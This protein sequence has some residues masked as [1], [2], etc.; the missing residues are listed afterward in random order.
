MANPLSAFSVLGNHSTIQT[1]VAAA[2]NGRFPHALLLEGPR[3]SGKK[4]LARYLAAS[5]LCQGENPPCGVCNSCHKAAGDFHPD[6]VFYGLEESGARSF[7]IDQIRQLK[8][9]AYVLPNESPY[10][11]FILCGAQNM[12]VQAQNALLK[13]VEEPP[14]TC[15]FLLLCENRQAL[16]P[17]ILSRVQTVQMEPLSSREIE[18][19]LKERCPQASPQ[20][21]AQA[22]RGAQGWLGAALELLEAG[23][24]NI[25]A[26]S[27]QLLVMAA[28]ES[29]FTLAAALAPWEKDREGFLALLETM[30]EQIGRALTGREENLAEFSPLQLAR[31]ADIIEKTTCQAAQNGNL[32]LLTAVLCSRLKSAVGGG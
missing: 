9:S 7:H 23:E 6:I 21:I 8:L 3:G 18:N 15:V 20:A 10:K 1:L 11:V 26:K 28:R 17:T 30:K 27:R 5:L 14:A 12:T 24:E 16:L 13:L 29:E 4:T 19:A 31:M 22:A 25:Q 32:T 2:G